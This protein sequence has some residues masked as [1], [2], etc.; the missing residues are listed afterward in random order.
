MPSA[1]SVVLVSTLLV[2]AE[3]Y[4][5]IVFGTVVPHLLE[6]PGWKLTLSSVGTVGSMAYVGMLLGALATGPL[7]DRY[8]RRRPALTAIAWC[9]GWTAACAA[10]SSPGQLGLFRL[11]AGMGAGAVMP[12]AIALCKEHAKPGRTNI[13]TTVLMAGV[14]LGGILASLLALPLLPAWGWRGLFVTG[15]LI[16]V[17]VLAV[18]VFTLPESHHFGR[19]ARRSREAPVSVLLG[20]GRRAVAVLC[21]AVAF[22]NLLAWYGLT[23]WVTELMH[24]LDFPLSSALQFS[25]TLNIG[26]VV[27]SLFFGVLADRY[28]ARRLAPAGSAIAATCLAFLAT[29]AGGSA[30]LL[31]TVVAVAGMGAQSALNLLNAWV[32]DHY[33]PSSRASALGWVN[34]IG[35]AGAILAPSL[36]GWILDLSG[37]RSVFVFFAAAS[38]SATALLLTLAHLTRRH[39]PA[40]SAV[41]TAVPAA[42]TS[43]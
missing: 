6:E 34:G 37:P 28:G 12:A 15:S 21:A 2:M 36:G 14:P 9:T 3:G 33:P 19:D 1:R 39:R 23:T 25:L 17:A 38:A 30:V 43:H 4:D 27:G 22:A 40:A 11:L 42:P 8:G 5:L 32:A 26:A 16:G 41:T 7:S 35:R 18:A 31:L 29:Q 20:Q 13:A 10:A 24:K